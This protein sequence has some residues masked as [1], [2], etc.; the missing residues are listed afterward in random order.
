M[1]KIAANLSQLYQ[2]AQEAMIEC[3]NRE[4]L[5]HIFRFRLFG[6][7]D[8]L[9]LQWQRCEHER[10]KFLYEQVTI[11]RDATGQ[12]FNYLLKS[13]EVWTLDESDEFIRINFLDDKSIL[14]MR[15]WASDEVA[16]ALVNSVSQDILQLPFACMM[17]HFLDHGSRTVYRFIADCDKMIENLQK[18]FNREAQ[19]QSQYVLV[20]EELET[21]KQPSSVFI[22]RILYHAQD[23]RAVTTLLWKLRKQRTKTMSTSIDS[24]STPEDSL[25][26]SIPKIGHQHM[27]IL[28][29]Y[30][31]N[32]TCTDLDLMIE[33]LLSKEKAFSDWLCRTGNRH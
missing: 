2:Q 33:N 17:H 29:K 13:I 19:Y 28:E 12:K 26:Q 14:K 8:S 3:D 31:V 7:H 30:F 11:K 24:R 25:N 16:D 9:R 4:K 15:D 23:T 21:F 22:Q 32:T 1:K 5:E 18:V 6:S 27:Q 20:W 10:R